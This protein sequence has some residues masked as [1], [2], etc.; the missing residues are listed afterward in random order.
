MRSTTSAF[1]IEA[2]I[3]KVFACDTFSFFS[4]HNASNDTPDT[5]TT[6]NVTPPI[7]PFAF[8]FLPKPA[9]KTSTH[10]SFL[11]LI[12]TIVLINEVQTPIIRHKT[13]NPTSTPVSTRPYFFP[14]LI[15]CT[16]THFR[17]AELGCLASIPIFSKTMPFPWEAP[18]R[19]EDFQAVPR[20]RLRKCSSAQRFSRRWIRSL[21]AALR[22]AG[23]PLPIVCRW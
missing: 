7:S 4:F 22:P 19:G 20:A 17:T 12:H 1:K 6:L 18:L 14:F 23:L 21:R 3:S 10:Q 11:L 9:I 15:N 8:P 16:R 5:L 2:R 13:R